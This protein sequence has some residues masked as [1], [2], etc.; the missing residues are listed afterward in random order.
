M[1][2]SCRETHVLLKCDTFFM[3]T[4][5]L[6]MGKRLGKAQRIPKANINR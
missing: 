3:E 4:I 6:S 1:Q 2:I 5:V